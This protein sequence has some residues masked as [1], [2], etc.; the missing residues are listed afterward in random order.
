MKASADEWTRALF[1]KALNAL[2]IGII[3][4]SVGAIAGILFLVYRALG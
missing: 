2:A 3:A 1:G 4:F